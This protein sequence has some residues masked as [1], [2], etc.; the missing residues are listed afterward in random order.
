MLEL[1]RQKLQKS[2]IGSAGILDVCQNAETKLVRKYQGKG[3]IVI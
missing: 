2:Q 3:C 1:V